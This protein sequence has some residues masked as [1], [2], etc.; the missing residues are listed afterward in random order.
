MLTGKLL[1]LTG[2]ACFMLLVRPERANGQ[3]R[4][5]SVAD[6]LA[7]VETGQPQIT[8]SREQ[9]VAAGINTDLI[10]NTLIP[11]LTAGYQAGYATDNNITGLSYPGLLLPISGPVGPRSSSTVVPGTALAVLLQ[12]SPFTFGQRS[13]AIGKAEAQFRLAGSAHD[14]LLFQQRYAAISTYMNVLYLQRLLATE[15]D[16][17]SRART[18]LGQSLVLAKEGLRPG[19]DTVLF[20]S[21][22]AQAAMDQLKTQGLYRAQLLELWRQT[23]LPDD[24]DNLVLTDTLMIAGIP[25]LT[26][27]GSAYTQNPGYRYF[28][29]QVALSSANLDQ[30][31]KAWRPSLNFWANAFSRGSGIEPDGSIDKAQ[32]W[33]LSRTNYA[34]GI[35][36]SFPILQFAAVHLQKQQYQALLRADQAQLS[37]VAINIR[38]QVET[39]ESNYQQ[40]LLV[41]AEA[42]VQS[43]AA[44][45]SYQGLLLSYQNGLV[46]FTQL[47]QGQYQLLNAETAEAAANLEVWKALLDIGVA[48]GNLNL[49]TDQLK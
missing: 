8:A 11:S 37:Q 3:K 24:G 19:L 44:R 1:L 12:W 20:Q 38:R 10:R 45:L 36:L 17:V 31:K 33:E 15:E 23:G 21:L 7:L 47:S 49:F 27:T 14:N 48:K 28:E 40:S 4:T 43:R 32:G 6:V 35:Q 22:L 41:A 9:A 39:A 29:A 42:P 26:D 5:L 46:D 16:N 13:A 18:G 34:A 25:A 30:A 2:C